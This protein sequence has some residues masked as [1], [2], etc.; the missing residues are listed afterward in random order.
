[1]KPTNQLKEP[2]IQYILNQMFWMKSTIMKVKHPPY[3][4]NLVSYNFFL[5]PK[6]KMHLK[7]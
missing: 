3:Y 6:L 2:C 4:P 7:C 1:M 5:F